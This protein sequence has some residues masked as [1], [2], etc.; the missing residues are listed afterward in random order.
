MDEQYKRMI[1]LC[2]KSE[3]GAILR[4][5]DG[6]QYIAA[7]L[8]DDVGRIV[9]RDELVLFIDLVGGRDTYILEPF[10][11]RDEDPEYEAVMDARG[12]DIVVARALND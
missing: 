12:G 10:V 6:K 8:S 2:E 11:Y 1:E 7:R 5:I 4:S 9:A 3:G